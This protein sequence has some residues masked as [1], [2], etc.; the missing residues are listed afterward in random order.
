MTGVMDGAKVGGFTP[1]PWLVE[2]DQGYFNIVA[3]GREWAIVGSEGIDDEA[4]A[5]LIAAAPDLFAAAQTAL[6]QITDQ[7]MSQAYYVESGDMHADLAELAKQL[8]AAL[9]KAQGGRS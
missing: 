9:A 7:R 5:R 8:R 3:V 2:P 1:G 6:A 4:N